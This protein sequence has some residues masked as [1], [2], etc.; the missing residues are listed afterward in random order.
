MNIHSQYIWISV[1][2]LLTITGCKIG[3]PYQQPAIELQRHF[4]G[5][6]L[7]Q[8]AN[9]KVLQQI[10]WKDFF[11]DTL[12]IQLVE[13]GLKNNYDMRSALLN[14][15]ISNE[16][17]KYAKAGY[18]PDV[19]FEIGNMNYQWR[20]SD[21]RSAASAKWYADKGTTAPKDMFL[22]QSDNAT[23]INFNWEAD[24]WG[25]ISYQN[26][27]AAANFLQTEVA[28]HAIQTQIIADI[29]KGYFNLLMLDA[30]IEVAK[31]NV[32]LNDSTL[33][34]IKL[35]FEAGEITALAMQQ[36]ESQRLIAASLVP[37]LEQQIATQENSLFTLVGRM[38][39]EI[40]RKMNLDEVMIN[41]T[42][43]SFGSPLDLIRNRPDIRS[44]ELQLVARN[45][46]MN[47]TQTMRYP[48]VSIGGS[49]GLNA[50]M[51][52]NWF[53][54]PGALFGNLVGGITQ[55]VFKK[56]KL[57]TDYEVAKLEREKSE[58]DFQ[59]TVLVSINEVSSLLTAQQKQKEQYQIAEQRVRNSQLAVKNASLLFKSGYATYLEVITAQG[60]ALTSDLNLVAI[61]QQQLQTYVDLYRSLG[62][63]W[64]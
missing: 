56:R 33:N 16:L 5:D 9:G 30:Q 21:F 15:R 29:A 8:N 61:K 49:F 44:A 53:N 39:T 36:T 22:L 55:P 37:Q 60:N 10:N 12:L 54:I 50:M 19:D 47:I 52:Q 31:R 18:L 1:L 25:K 64:N 13:E 2:I 7:I 48:N 59:K 26:E 57:K 27:K 43:I 62:G 32:K 46:D 45:A 11:Q 17:V 58:L 63:G 34:M 28:K 20:S 4:R 35:Q 3:Q 38:P 6:T 14:I 24:V 40:N 51:P 23:R 42:S 41:D